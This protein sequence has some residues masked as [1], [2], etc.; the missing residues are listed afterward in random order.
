MA[1]ID[2][3][4]AGKKLAEAL[5]AYKESRP[6]ILA[7]PRG[8]VAVAAAIA[9]AL[10]APLDLILVRKIG[11]PLQPELAM[12]AAVDGNDPT[13]VRNEDVIALARITG[14]EF[15]QA[16]DHELAEIERRRELYLGDRPRAEPGGHT[17][18]VVDDG[19]ATG[20]TMRAALQAVRKRKPEKLVLAVPVAPASTL[21][22]LRD[23]ADE[24]V[25]LE[26]PEPFIAISIHYR[27]FDQVAD[28][29]VI[30]M[31][32]QALMPISCTF[33]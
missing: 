29:D 30:R 12:G 28:G 2:R 33:R 15:K 17:V 6:I 20:A 5:I 22:D 21:E 19:L 23:E 3:E 13:I 25:C 7:L 9:P 27:N 32:S 16:C 8:G 18:I 10:N 31:L 14:D 24:I 11:C 26:I 4:E 1:F